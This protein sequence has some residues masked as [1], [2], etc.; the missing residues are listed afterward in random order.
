[1]LYWENFDDPAA[2]PAI[3]AYAD[4]WQ[5]ADKVV[6]SRTIDE[7]PSERTGLTR[8][9]DA[10]AVRALKAEATVPISV[11]G[12][13]LA[14]QAI[15]DGLVDDIHQFVH[16]VIIGGGTRF[17]PPDVHLKLELVDEH[18]FADGVVYLHYRI[19]GSP[20]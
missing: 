20:R 17:L 8:E 6:F 11:G 14:A 13:T 15:R 4:L 18:R 10:R 1:M 3:R 2:T 7:T 9:F 12:A 5:D 16:P 19:P